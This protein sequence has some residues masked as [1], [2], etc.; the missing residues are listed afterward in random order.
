M[1]Y[2]DLFMEGPSVYI[3]VLAISLLI[4][5]AVYC[6]FPLLYAKLR[7]KPITARKYR[8]HC[9]L[10][11]FLVML[12]FKLVTA[13]SSASPYFLWTTVFTYSGVKGLRNRGMILD[14]K[15]TQYTGKCTQNT[16][17]ES[18]AAINTDP[19][20][21][22]LPAEITSVKPNEINSGVRSDFVKRGIIRI[23]TGVILLV[24][25]IIA[26][27]GNRLNGAVAFSPVVSSA[28]L[29]F[30]LIYY[31][32]YYFVGIVGLLLLI[33]GLCAYYDIH[34]FKKKEKKASAPKSRFCKHCGSPIDPATKKCTGCGKQY[35]R[36]P[37][38]KGSSLVWKVVAV[39]S[40]IA[41]CLCIYRITQL[42]TRLSDMQSLV[43]EQE[44][45]I[46]ELSK[47]GES[48]QKRIAEKSSKV[49]SL[50]GDINTLKRKNEK[51]E[52]VYDFCNDHV[53]VVSDDGTRKY[54]KIQCIYFDDSCFWAYNLE[55]A[56][57]QGYKPCSFCFSRYFDSLAN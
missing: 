13:G 46:A 32:S 21:N 5:I 34:I 8:V 4:T 35:F 14:L 57:Q 10:V 1:E 24:L 36:L 50:T 49:A 3:P 40:V 28:Q 52:K 43:T 7:R 48:L 54:H 29:L 23:I 42:E 56:Q 16:E 25:Q 53:V 9:F 12:V 55:A 22:S 51:M 39:L 15:Q 26:V 11:N 6:A 18:D 30:Y 2:Y 20:F 45:K 37:S 19:T 44:A 38:R 41:V 31:L 47:T 17:W 27:I 33:S